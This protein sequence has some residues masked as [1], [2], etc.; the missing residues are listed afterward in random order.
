VQDKAASPE[1]IPVADIAPAG[2]VGKSRMEKEGG[3]KGGRKGRREGGIS[4]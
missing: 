1:N 2:I 3:M 4:F